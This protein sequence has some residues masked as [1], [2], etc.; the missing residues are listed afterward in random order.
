MT[1]EVAAEWS[2][3]VQQQTADG[4]VDGIL[5]HFDRSKTFKKDRALRWGCELPTT[6]QICEEMPLII[7]IKISKWDVLRDDF[8][9]D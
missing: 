3:S 2:V 7:T 4:G 6:V 5:Y 9:H 8:M 1:I